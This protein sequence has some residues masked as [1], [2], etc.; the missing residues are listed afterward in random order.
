[1][2]KGNS[3]AMLEE[4][5]RGAQ[6]GDA[7]IENIAVQN[8][9]LQYCTGCLKCNLL[10]RCAIRND[11]WQQLSQQILAA[12]VLVFASPIYFHH[13]PAPVKKILDRFRSFMQVQ[14]TE[15]GLK[16]TPWQEWRK[17]FVLLLALG[18]PLPDDAQPIIDLFNF[19][20]EV[21]G[22][23]NKLSVIIGTR[24]AVANQVRLSLEELQLLYTKLKLP[25]ALAMPDYRQNQTTLANCYRLGQIIALR[26]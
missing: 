6:D 25:A 15:Y 11:D 23:E 16:H 24:L 12:D 10:Q 8:I 20:I 14:I 17:H 5:L 7:Q 26:D 9:H 3:S 4:F 22:S 2:P 18:S 21:L 1:R 13:F 19:M